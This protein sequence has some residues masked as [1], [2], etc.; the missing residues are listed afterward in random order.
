M[1]SIVRREPLHT[2]RS[3]T[4]VLAADN[5]DTD[6]IIPARFLTVTT[7]DGLGTK[8]FADWRYDAQGGPRP[9]SPLDQPGAAGARILIAGRNFGCGSSREH[10][11]WALQDFG[12]AAVLARSLADIFRRNAL[13]NGLLAVEVD[14]AAHARLL[15][16]PGGEVTLDLAAQTLTLGGG[17][18]AAFAI[19]S[20][21]RHCLL[22]GLDELEFLLGQE[23]AIAAFEAER[24]G[25]GDPAA[26]PA[27]ER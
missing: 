21:A 23:A 17:A 22:S 15:A 4:L 25:A 18:P 3:R 6:Q 20:F 27:A 1:Q 9:D 10:A 12:F 24:R 14:A 13:Q 2:L 19:D 8:L 26:G 16:E 7:R 11:V 5:V